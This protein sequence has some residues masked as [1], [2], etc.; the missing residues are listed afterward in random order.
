MAQLKHKTRKNGHDKAAQEIRR[1]WGDAE[2][3]D[4]ANDLRIFI[5]PCD[6][7]GAT[8]KDPAH[9][10]FAR[11]CCRQFGTTKVLFFRSVAYVGLKT[12]RGTERVER[13]RMSESMRSLVEAFD[14]GEPT[15]PEAGFLLKCPV[16]SMGLNERN[17]RRK[18]TVAKKAR[19][20]LE[21]TAETTTEGVGQGKGKFRDEPLA[22]DLAVRSGTGAVQF[23]KR[24]SAMRRSHKAN[25]VSETELVEGKS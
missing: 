15:I 13:F 19:A 12:E 1:L 22:I 4:A 21:G 23:T 2:V 25:V 8:K 24:A 18:L 20:K 3:V 11:A 10:V 6:L 5:Q 17:K 16:P 9:C 14:R 7:D